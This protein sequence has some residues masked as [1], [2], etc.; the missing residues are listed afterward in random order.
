MEQHDAPV[1]S[2]IVP[3]H[4]GAH[5]LGALLAALEAQDLAEPWEVV[6]VV[7]GPDVETQALL[8]PH[9]DSLPLRVVV[10]DHSNGVAAALNAGYSEARGRV[11]VR[12]DDDLTPAPSM[13]RRHLE[14]HQ[15]PEPVG[16]IGPTRDALPDTPYARAYGR[17]ANARSVAAAYARPEPARWLGWAAHN[18]LTR[19]SWEAV[20]GFDESF[21]YREDSDLGLR[22]AKHGVRLIVDPQLEIEHRGAAG[23]AATRAARA[24]VSGASEVLFATRHPDAGPSLETPPRSVRTRVWSGATV[25][26]SALLR[27]RRAA[28]CAGWAVDRLLPLVSRRA[29]GRMVALVVEASARAGRRGGNPDQTAYRIQKDAELAAERR[30]QR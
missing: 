4:R 5:R 7:D 26:L 17:P 27:G 20:G 15:G 28:G 1:A 13:L 23:N 19:D 22:L 12:C 21:A 9:R 16:V 10:R 29:G 11:L 30:N 14:H 8:D 25:L 6:V 2:V 3:T 18:S 24:W